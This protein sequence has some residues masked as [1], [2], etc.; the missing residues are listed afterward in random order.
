M[1]KQ[2]SALFSR[3]GW[4]ALLF[5]ALLTCG[6]EPLAPLVRLTL[7]GVP[8]DADRVVL[9]V[10]RDDKTLTSELTGPGPFDII[11]AGF[12]TGATG[13]ATFSL[14]IYQGDCLV[15][16]GNGRLSITGDEVRELP[17]VVMKPALVC[18][19][20]AA[21]VLVQIVN[22]AG[23]SGRVTSRPAGIDCGSDCEEVYAANASVVLHAEPVAGQGVFLGWA[24][25]CTDTSDC[26]L[27]L[28]IP[29]NYVVQAL[30]GTR[31]CTGWC[32]EPSGTTANLY[33]IWGV[34]PLDVMAVGAG[35][36]IVHWDGQSWSRQ[37]TSSTQTLRSVTVPRGS[38]DY[39]AVGFNGTILKHSA[40][41]WTQLTDP[42][43][44][45][46]FYGVAGTAAAEVFIVG[47]TGT[48]LKGSSQTGLFTVRPPNGMSGNPPSSFAGKQLNAIAAASSIAKHALVGEMGINVNQ[49]IAIGTD[50]FDDAALGTTSDLLAVRFTQTMIFAAG[51]GGTIVRRGPANAFGD[52]PDWT[53]QTSPVNVVL[54]GL[55]GNTD[56]LVYAVGDDVTILS[57]DGTG[58]SKL[59]LPGV[60]L[61][62]TLS[63]NAIWGSG[64]NNIYVVGNNGTILHYLP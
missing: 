39:I 62:P 49:R 37:T 59:S 21:K 24:G 43:A 2:L 17:I 57:F 60:S 36:V 15:G 12:P 33:G 38:T 48:V 25:A 28:A 22:S 26:V 34:G 53:V 47:E 14:L 6:S 10:V 16:S 41:T 44:G 7:T 55:W 58:W 35:G 29:G 18:G 1:G 61:S 27:N 23:S 9:T 11:T 56:T 30:F 42:T 5:F 32:V 13:E 20:P 63:L 45:K 64:A 4:M 54:R 50:T 3:T 31:T 19:T 40:N 51:S 8:P 52:F 46:S